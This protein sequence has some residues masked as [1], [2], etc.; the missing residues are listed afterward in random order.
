MAAADALL[1]AKD[2]SAFRHI[3]WAVGTV[4]VPDHQDPADDLLS[5]YHDWVFQRAVAAQVAERAFAMAL[6]AAADDD[7]PAV[8]Q[9]VRALREAHSP[10]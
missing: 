7:D 3:L 8:V 10:M 1:A 5:A 6:D 2:A 9:G 4:T